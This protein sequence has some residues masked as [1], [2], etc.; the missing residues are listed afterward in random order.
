MFRVH[1]KTAGSF[2]LGLI[3]LVFSLQGYS[4]DIP[5]YTGKKTLT[6]DERPQ[7][8]AGVGIT[9][10]LGAS[11]DLS[12]EVTDEHGQKR[13]LGDFLNQDKPVIISPVYYSCPGL[14]NF[15]LNGLTDGLKQLDWNV[16]EKFTVL[17]MSFDSK[18]GF[19][20][21][22]KKKA[23]YMKVYDRPGTEN[24]WHFLTMTEEGVRSFTEKIGFGFKWNEEVKEWSHASA[25]IVVTPQGVISRYLP[26]IMF[27]ARDLKLALNEA[28]EGKIGNFIESLV[29]YC[30][31]YNAHTSKYSLVAFNV[32]KLGGLLIILVLAIWLLPFWIR[33]R[34]E[35]NGAGSR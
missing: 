5:P 15:H 4:R 9:E 17:A 7:E 33:S 20:V 35:Q 32:M 2:I 3:G 1:K 19:E 8:L 13:R 28:T 10:K 27:E 14:C 18:E 24:G 11:L 34:H 31:K 6:S 22:A 30:F 25:A 26:G 23:N 29:L 21:A 16:G 12:L